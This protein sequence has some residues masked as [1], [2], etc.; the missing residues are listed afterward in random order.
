MNRASSNWREVKLRDVAEDV[1]V[2][3][4][5]SMASEYRESGVIFL[6]SQNVVPHGFD[7]SDVRYI[8][9]E[10]HSKL[11]KSALRAGDVVTV[12]TGKPGATA[13][14]PSGWDMANCSD[15]VITRP[16]PEL[17][18]RWLS[19]FINSAASGFISARLVGAVQQHFNVGAARDIDL[20]LPPL[21]EQC[22]I[23]EVLGALDDKIAAN[24]KL[25]GVTKDL[26]A[27]RFS[28]LEMD[29]DHGE[30]VHL[31]EYFEL[32]PKCAKPN[33]DE[34]TYLDMQ[35]LP[36]SD[37]LISEWDKRPAKSG[38][39]FMNGDTLL[40]RITPCLENGK[41][42]YVD[43]LDEGEVGLG[44]TEYIVFRARPGTPKELAF[45]LTTSSRFRVTA[46]QHMVGTS[47]R[48]RLSATDVAGFTVGRVDD[49]RIIEWGSIASPLVD[50]LGSLRDENRTLAGLR[51]TLLPRLISGELRVRDAE[52]VV[53]N[54]V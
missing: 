5:G 35:K 39:R 24:R 33:A 45:F 7:L 54:A 16:G 11:Q 38:T 3:H 53:S 36:T 41:V 52:E 43:F 50:H 14:V 29:V 37:V 51:D 12:R 49:S 9:T 17:D 46:M 21:P 18:A 48:Q 25:A 32:N 20:L 4:V 34:P 23:A 31:D 26:L 22:A 28:A 15:L 2:G 1:T 6:R 13:V 19:Y 47:G 42:G 27:A 10:F 40:A 30:Q 44:S 8:S